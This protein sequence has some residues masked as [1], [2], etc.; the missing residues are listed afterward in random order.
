[1]KKVKGFFIFESI[2]AIIIS[3]VAVSCLYLTVAESRKNGREMELKTDRMYAYHVLKTNDLD[4]VVVHDHIYE[5][6]G[7]QYLNDKTTNQKFKIQN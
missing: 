1:M 4:Q 3:L 5:R 7:Q 6:A 2:V